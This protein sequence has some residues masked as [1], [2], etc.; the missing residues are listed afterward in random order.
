MHNLVE[1]L[2]AYLL[3]QLSTEG[4]VFFKKFLIGVGVFILLY[5]LIKRVVAYLKEKIE[6]NHLW[7]QNDIEKVSKLLTSI[8]FILLSIFNFLIFLQ[9]LGIDVAI[10]MWGIGL[11]FAFSLEN[12]IANIIA[13][14][15]IVLNKKFTIGDLISIEGKINMTGIIENITLRYTV[16]KSFDRRRTIIP[17][18]ELAKSPFKTIKSE[19]YIRGELTVH[20][21]RYVHLEQVKQLITTT[22]NANH[23]IVQP[24]FTTTIVSWFD[25][26][27]IKLKG[28]FL[29]NP[30]VSSTGFGAKTEIRKALLEIFSQYGIKI[31]YFHIT[32]DIEG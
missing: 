23:H 7:N 2:K 9:I 3:H 19:K 18:T 30:K 6:S 13:G 12:I 8:I 29:V 4:F 14:I 25:E 24:D 17:N 10:L 28:F 1:N 20:V 16:I 11:G 21:P 32:L 15:V 26:K 5:T 27:G 22:I 31:P